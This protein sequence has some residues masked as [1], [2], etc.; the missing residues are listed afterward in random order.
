MSAAVATARGAIEEIVQSLE[1]QAEK[2]ERRRL[3][4][5]IWMH[6]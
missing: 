6:G 5:A 4:T 2:D 1:A 3:Q